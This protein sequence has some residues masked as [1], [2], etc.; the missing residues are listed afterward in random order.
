MGKEVFQ[1]DLLVTV[2]GMIVDGS[3]KFRSEA[4]RPV[5][6]VAGIGAAASGI[7]DAGFALSLIHI[8]PDLTKKLIQ[9]AL[10]GKSMKHID[11]KGTTRY[12]EYSFYSFE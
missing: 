11:Y 7:K 5:V 10:S 2:M 9:S 1:T 6:G 4:D 3:R 12:G 8:F